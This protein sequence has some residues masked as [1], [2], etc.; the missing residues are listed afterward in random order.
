MNDKAQWYVVN[1]NR[2]IIFSLI[3]TSV[4]F[5]GVINNVCAVLAAGY[6]LWLPNI[7]KMEYN[8][9]TSHFKRLMKKTN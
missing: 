4:V 2:F 9:L 3:V 7:E 6:W 8:F 5:D 1:I